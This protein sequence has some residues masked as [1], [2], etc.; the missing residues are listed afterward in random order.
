MNLFCNETQ[1]LSILESLPDPA[2]ILSESGVYLGIFGGTDNRYYHDGSSLMGRRIHDVIEQEQAD[3]F[4]AQITA[5]L[6]SNALHIVEY[7]LA[8]FNVSGLEDK[9]G[10]N[11]FIY[12]EGRVK[13]L[14]GLFNNERAVLWI[15]SN[16]SERHHLEMQLRE[17]S[18]KDALTKLYNR[19]KLID[20]LEKEFHTCNNVFS[21]IMFDLDFFKNINDSYGHYVGDNILKFVADEA[22]KVI[23]KDD[24]LARVGGEEFIILMRNTTKQEAFV[25]A[26]RLRKHIE[27]SDLHHYNCAHNVTIS[28]GITEECHP[29]GSLDEMVKRVDQALYEAKNKGRNTSVVF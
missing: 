4:C 13:S 22:L 3:W 29:K 14:P 23:R 17:L 1:L 9:V 21:L 27:T 19:R 10:P 26:E 5:A 6:L 16:I 24:I 18:E 8:N 28:L 11:E 2:F 15:A 20:E 12:F 7:Q 25:F